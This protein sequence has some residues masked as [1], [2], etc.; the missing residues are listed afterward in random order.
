MS[1]DKPIIGWAAGALFLASSLGMTLAG[2]DIPVR[3][4]FG[5]KWKFVMWSLERLRQYGEGRVFARWAAPD[6]QRG[7]RFRLL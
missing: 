5:R 7:W 3:Y 4:G 2:A 1:V 6:G